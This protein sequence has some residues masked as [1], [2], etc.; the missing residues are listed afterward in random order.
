M[1]IQQD[2]HSGIFLGLDSAGTLSCWW[3]IT[4]KNPTKWKILE[5]NGVCVCICICICMCIYIYI[6]ICI[7]YPLYTAMGM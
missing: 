5:H 7:I 3:Y 2:V 1:E 4:N 6:C